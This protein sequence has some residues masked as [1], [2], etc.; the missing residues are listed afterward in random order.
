MLAVIE[1]RE[2]GSITEHH[3]V[4]DA[5]VHHLAHN[6][7]GTAEDMAVV[8]RRVT[9]EELRAKTL[10]VWRDR[11]KLPKRTGPAGEVWFHYFEVA[12]LVREAEARKA[13]RKT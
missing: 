11:G 9:G 10:Y 2:A 4:A 12:Q 5:E 13:K 7:T 1:P 3:H 6:A 8:H